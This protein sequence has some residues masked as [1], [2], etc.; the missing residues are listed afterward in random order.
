MLSNASQ[1]YGQFI[2]VAVPENFRLDKFIIFQLYINIT[3]KTDSKISYYYLTF[4][5]MCFFLILNYLD[6]VYIIISNAFILVI[7]VP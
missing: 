5:K 2:V 6:F 4:A 3:K 1:F 7:N